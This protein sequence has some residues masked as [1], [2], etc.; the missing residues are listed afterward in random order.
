MEAV[1]FPAC[2]RSEHE[3]V[4]AV[5]RAVRERY[6]Q[7]DRFLFN[8]LMKELPAWFENHV[9]GMDAALAFHLDSIGFDFEQGTLKPLAEG[10]QRGAGCACASM[11]T[12]EAA[13]T[14]AA[15]TAA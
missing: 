1:N 6:V 8:N 10:E 15:A 9:N 4:L 13:S 11:N 7:G 14:T 2:H 3:R 12:P 5:I